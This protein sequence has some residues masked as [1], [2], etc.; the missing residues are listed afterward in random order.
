[1]KIIKTFFVEKKSPEL[2]FS[3]RVSN[4]EDKRLKA[5]FGIEFNLS[6]KTSAFGS[7]GKLTPSQNFRLDDEEQKVSVEFNFAKEAALWYFPIQT[8]SESERGLEKTRQGLSLLF[9]WPIS[10]EREETW[11][12][13][14]KLTAGCLSKKN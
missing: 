6:L 10:L 3:Y 1:M 5:L 4:P 13:E 11:N 9:L 7:R 14:G 2:N 8:V 12:L